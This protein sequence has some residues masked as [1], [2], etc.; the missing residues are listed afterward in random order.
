MRQN[1]SQLEK[2]TLSDTLWDDPDH[3]QTILQQLNAVKNQLAEV[4]GLQQYLE[5][6][7]TALELA[8]SEVR[9]NCAFCT[10]PIDHRQFCHHGSQYRVA[11]L[12][13]ATACGTLLM[14]ALFVPAPTN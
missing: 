8:S 1:I 9:H 7:Q 12:S 5:D 14:R 4:Q 3:A 6:I 10:M 13:Y 11:Y 2:Q